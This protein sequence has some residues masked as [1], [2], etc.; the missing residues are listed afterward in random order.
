MGIIFLTQPKVEKYY[1]IFFPRLS[2]GS[3]KIP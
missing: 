2:A 3:F 1:A